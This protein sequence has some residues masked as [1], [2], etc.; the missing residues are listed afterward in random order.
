[1]LEVCVA[2]SLP[3]TRLRMS[4]A[5]TAVLRTWPVVAC[6]N[7]IGESQSGK[8]QAFAAHTSRG[9]AELTMTPF[10][11]RTNTPEDPDRA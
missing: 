9:V 4:P 11:T 5:Y 1:M 7:G 3:R 2:A 10:Y 6:A 8:D